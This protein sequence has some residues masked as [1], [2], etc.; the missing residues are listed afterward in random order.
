[1]RIYV[2]CRKSERTGNEYRALIC[3]VGGTETILTLDTRTI[4]RVMKT[5]GHGAK[6]YYLLNQGETL[7]LN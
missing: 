3:N 6:E 1:M 7:E 2:A 4:F 5:C